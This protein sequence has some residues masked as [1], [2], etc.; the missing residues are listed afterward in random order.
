MAKLKVLS[1]QQVCQ[2]LNVS[3]AQTKDKAGYRDIVVE[4]QRGKAG[5]TAGTWPQQIFTEETSAYPKVV[6]QCTAVV[7]SRFRGNDEIRGGLWVFAGGHRDPPLRLRSGQAP[8]NH[9]GC[10]Y[11]CGG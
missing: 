1:G 8:D 4:A 7:D 5:H 6:G 9:G 10:R 3:K 2:I 11:E